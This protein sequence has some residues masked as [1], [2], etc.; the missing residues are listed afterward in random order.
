[1]KYI[2]QGSEPQQ[3]IKWKK[4]NSSNNWDEFSKPISRS[5]AIYKELKETLIEQQGKM[6][7]YCEV[8]LKKTTDAHIEHLKDKH[9][10]PK[11]MFNFKNLL[12]SCQHNDCCGHKKG[13]K[14][15]SKMVSPYDDDCQ[16]RFTYTGNGKII[17]TDETD[18]SAQRTIDLLELNCRR[19]K[20]WRLSLI[21][22][23]DNE[24]IDFEKSLLNCFDWYQGFY[25]V[26]QYVANKHKLSI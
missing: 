7:C 5:Y 24:H 26:I 20:D 9:N 4:V 25:T 3:F 11:E 8:A 22:M 15:Y 16:S 10:Y 6:C 21:R 19:L 1:M 18:K 17:P 2:E 12:A 23:I 13:S 14:Y